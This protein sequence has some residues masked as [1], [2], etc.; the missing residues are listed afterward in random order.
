MNSD[1]RHQAQSRFIRVGEFSRRE[2]R[3]NGFL[4][5]VLLALIFALGLPCAANAQSALTDDGDTQTGNTPNL[6]LTSSSNVYLK[7][8]L[9]STLPS[10][11]PGSSV[12]KATI[13]LYLGAVKT[14]GIVDVY[15]VTS[16]W[17]ERTV[18]AAP[19]LL[20]SIV[21]SGVAVQSD[22]EGKFLVLDV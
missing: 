10:N 16:N 12:A 9:S 15:Q 17:S 20:G 2:M 22:Q 14:P 7:F 8:K 19:P 11:T 1:T 21:Q 18:A 13:K 3:R 5:R 6:T 4:S